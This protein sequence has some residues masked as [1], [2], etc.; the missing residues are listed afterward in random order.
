MWSL[1]SINELRRDG[2][3]CERWNILHPNETPRT[4]FIEQQLQSTQ[5]PVI[6]ATD[7]MKAFPDMLRPYIDRPYVSLGT[8]GYG[9]S[10][11]RK[12][13][14]EFFEVDCNYICVTALKLMADEAMVDTSVVLTAI[15]RYGIDP[16]RPD[17]MSL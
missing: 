11:T 3:S 15:E 9:R 16:E 13:L 2:M 17:P 7:Y 6:A 10:D 4:S 8:D 1:T 5:G 12:K 14:R